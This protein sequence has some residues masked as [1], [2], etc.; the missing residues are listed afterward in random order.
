MQDFWTINSILLFGTVNSPTWKPKWGPLFSLEWKGLVFE[1][2][3]QPKNRVRELQ[4]SGPDTWLVVEG[5][6]TATVLAS[7]GLPIQTAHSTLGSGRL[8]SANRGG[9]YALEV[10]SAW[11]SSWWLNQPIWKIFVKMGIFPKS[12]WKETYL[13]PP[14]SYFLNGLDPQK[15]HSLLFFV[16]IRVYGFHH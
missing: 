4:T 6:V 10:D 15:R 7:I 2:I 16:Y 14:P 1:G 3:F 9:Q 13:K 8:Q 11:L 5:L 12:G